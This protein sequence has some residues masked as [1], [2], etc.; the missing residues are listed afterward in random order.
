[1]TRVLLCSGD[2]ELGYALRQALETDILQA[3]NVEIAGHAVTSLSALATLAGTDAD[4]DDPDVDVVVV[5]DRIG[6]VQIWD[7]VRQIA[8]R[9]PTVGIVAVV[10]DAGPAAFVTAMDAGVRGLLTRPISIEDVQARVQAAA[11]WSAAVRRALGATNPGGGSVGTT[12]ALAGSKGGVGTTTL[13][14][15]LALQVIVDDPTRSV[16]LVDL[17][18]QKGDVPGLLDIQHRHDIT[19]LV[20][21]AEELSARVL[22]D[23]LFAHPSGL[24]VLLA[25]PQ[26]EDGEEVSERAARLILGT[27]RSR[28]DVVIVDLGATVSDAGLVA[29]ELSDA[30]F[31]VATPD[32]L[33]LRG[34][35]RL[36]GVWE[37]LSATK[38]DQVKIILNRVDRRCDIQPD[39]ARRIVG[40]PVLDAH[41]PAGFR[42]LEAAVNRRAADSADP[43]FVAAVRDLAASM[44]LSRPP[45]P[46]PGRRPRAAREAGQATI[47]LPFIFLLICL[48]AVI[49]WQSV[50]V[51]ATWAL[52]G[53][54]ASEAARAAAVGNDPRAAA[55]ER[56]PAAWRDGL[57]VSTSGERV[58]I[59]VRTPLLMPGVRL[60]PL[61]VSVS[62]GTV[63]ER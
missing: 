34:V 31:V 54:A 15:H 13:A 58:T 63:S 49:A 53:N 16:C 25:P 4:R 5:D 18:L 42:G 62:A 2:D 30:T 32:V 45:A 37:R 38:E 47:E 24:K 46:Q 8:G 23:V 28:F 39:T 29:V 20:P 40:L 12:V 10:G 3:D 33:G 51:G 6:P 60:L 52:A 44:R 61:D 7:L 21:V 9:H 19:D 43:R 26:G 11:A 55:A 17:D 36:T 22:S 41:V 14:T 56:L 35:R 27:L 57:Q 50:L 1:M 59:R 48:L